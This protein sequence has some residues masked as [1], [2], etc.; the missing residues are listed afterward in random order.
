MLVR[1]FMLDLLGLRYSSSWG[2]FGD[3]ERFGV[4]TTDY[5]KDYV[6]YTGGG[7]VIKEHGKEQDDRQ[8]GDT[9]S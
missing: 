1:Y 9:F 7:K 8:Y 2:C 4:L 6:W 3:G 5:W